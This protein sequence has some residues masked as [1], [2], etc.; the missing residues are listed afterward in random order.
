[1]TD[2][3]ERSYTTTDKTSW[4]AGPW[5]HEPDKIQWVDD[6]T[7]YDCLIVRGPMGAL[8]GYVGVPPGHPCHG[9]D[10][11]DIKGDGGYIEVHGGLTYADAC[12][13][14]AEEGAGI[15]HVPF[16]GRPGDVWWF[17]FDCG[18]SYDL[19][20]RSEAFSG[21]TYRTVEYVRREASALAGQ[22]VTAR[23]RTPDEPESW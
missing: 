7:G 3:M 22:L 14:R 19:A 11:A 15:C 2:T 5:Q 20:P 8:C 23:R 10:Y 13:E 9:A 16:P 21:E 6:A 17:G 4:D 18:H 12:D 1:M